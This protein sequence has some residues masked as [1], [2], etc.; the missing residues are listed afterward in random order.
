MCG[1]NSRKKLYERENEKKTLSSFKAKDTIKM[2][3][4]PCA[5]LRWQI[6]VGVT[7]IK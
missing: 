1:K 5:L 4:A 2:K 3:A 6:T 7:V